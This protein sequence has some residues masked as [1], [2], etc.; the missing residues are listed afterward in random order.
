MKRAFSLIEILIVVAILGILAAIVMP[1]FVS[2]SALAKEAAAKDNLRILRNAIEL[3]A[4]QHN[5]IPPGYPGG[6]PSAMPSAAI[7]VLHLTKATNQSGQFANPG[8]DGYPYGPY[9]SDMPEN[10]FNNSIFPSVIRNSGSFPVKATG[11]AG[12]IYK[13]A[14]KEI[15]LDWPGTD[16]KGLPYYS[17]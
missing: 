7:F 5:G 8:T 16:E 1:Q 11:N 9:L 15:R 13:A 3:Y 6:N 12:W 4:V 10:P 17:Y 2:Q 14:N